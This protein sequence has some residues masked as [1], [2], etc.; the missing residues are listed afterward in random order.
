MAD[1]PAPLAKNDSID[2]VYSA[3]SADEIRDRYDVWA[4][5]YDADLAGKLG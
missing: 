3:T 5:G 4:A 1:E 2:S